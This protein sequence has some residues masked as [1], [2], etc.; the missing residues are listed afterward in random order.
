LFYN[1]GMDAPTIPRIVLTGGPCA[2]KSSA[3]A[4]VHAHLEAH[5]LSVYRVPEA[6]TLLLSGGIRVKD[7][8]LAH[9]VSF[10]VGIVRVQLALE[11]AFDTFARAAGR[12]AVL[13][14]DRGVI[15]G[16]A[17]LPRASWEDLLR[18]EGLDEVE[19]RERRYTAVV[20]LVTAAY[21]AE[22]A[23]GTLSNAVR[24]EDVE[25]AR[26][27]DLRLREAWRGHP[28]LCVIDNATDFEV[29][30]RRVVAA[31]SH[32]VGVPPAG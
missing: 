2:G 14:C 18:G 28:R 20:H 17:Y 30:L 19:L 27:V 10:Q 1:A 23:Y 22:G 25:G 29:K 11:S 6:S 8:P 15:D 16:A 32:I 3:L 21:G 9:M 7:A 12:P 24:Y 4:R 5:G 13:L 26:A 31:V